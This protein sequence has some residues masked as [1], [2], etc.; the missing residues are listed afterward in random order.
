MLRS[1]ATPTLRSLQRHNAQSTLTSRTLVSGVL[2]SRDA[3][4]GDKVAELKTELKQRGL[5]T[6]G[7]RADLI[8]RL[9]EDD[10]QKSGGSPATAAA[11]TPAPSPASAAPANKTQTRMASTKRG[12]A[13]SPDAEGSP[14]EAR[15][16]MS[17]GNVGVDGQTG[18]TVSHPP[19]MEPGQVSSNAASAIDA[20]SGI[21]PEKP[22][23]VEANPPGVPPQ[24]TPSAPI[25]FEVKVPYEAEVP[26]AGPEIVSGLPVRRFDTIHLC[27]SLFLKIH[28]HSLRPTSTQKHRRTRHHRSS[29][30]PRSSPSLARELFPMAAAFPT[31][32]KTATLQRS[33]RSSRAL[34]PRSHRTRAFDRPLTASSRPC[35]MIS[36]CL[37]HL[38]LR[39]HPQQRR[40]Q[41]QR[42]SSDRLLAAFCRMP[43][44]TSPS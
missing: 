18:A 13:K 24:H 32:A 20:A 33:R 7:R 38:H 43:R 23:P 29:R 6:Q 4:D 16:S 25:T 2:L 3:Y 5:S 12:D 39:R 34:P 8:R 42:N 22:I 36:A 10:K 30:H 19:D 44:T 14:S 31:R 21:V 35:E 26:D 9:L 1:L 41:R 17:S 11:G 28:S 27:S 37:P 15:P 40:R